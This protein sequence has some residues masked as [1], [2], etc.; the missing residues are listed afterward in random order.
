[1]ICWRSH[2]SARNPAQLCPDQSLT[3]QTSVCSLS[4]QEQSAHGQE[5]RAEE[6]GAEGLWERLSSGRG[7]GGHWQG[8]LVCQP[9][10]T[11][12]YTFPGALEVQRELVIQT[13]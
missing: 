2:S 12:A 7:G 8:L 5:A 4:E 11:R 3:L 13:H 10:G 6:E 1:M 9:A